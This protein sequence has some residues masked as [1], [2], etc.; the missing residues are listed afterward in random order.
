MAAIPMEELGVLVGDHSLF[1]ISTSQKFIKIKEKIIHPDYN[2]RGN[3]SSPLNNDIGLL[4]LEFPIIFTSQISPLCLPALGETGFGTTSA[5]GSANTLHYKRY[6]H[7]T[8]LLYN[9]ITYLHICVQ[10]GQHH[11]GLPG[12][13]GAGDRGQERHGARLG[14]DQRRRGLRRESA[15]RGG[16]RWTLY[17]HISTHIYTPHPV[18]VEILPNEDCHRLYGIMTENMMCTSGANAQGSCF[19]D[20][21]GPAIVRQVRGLS[22]VV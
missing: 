14:H 6:L 4:R 1:T 12:H 2:M 16:G 15:G 19:G 7:I 3:V 5:Y 9:H 20:S 8:Y 11:A 10:V 22:C 17:L 21:G 13:R 18:Q